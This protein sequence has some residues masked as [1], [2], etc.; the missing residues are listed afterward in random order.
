MSVKGS[1]TNCVRSSTSAFTAWPHRTLWR[2]ANQFPMSLVVAAYVSSITLGEL[3]QGGF[4]SHKIHPS[5]LKLALPA[6]RLNG[7]SSLPWSLYDQYFMINDI[8]PALR[9]GRGGARSRST[10]YYT[11]VVT[12]NNHMLLTSLSVPCPRGGQT[13]IDRYSTCSSATAT[14]PASANSAS[15]GSLTKKARSD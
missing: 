9:V 1:S 12:N 4:I 14:V 2:C 13:R 6:A 11:S 3:S 5:P 7:R 8:L 15:A 10:S